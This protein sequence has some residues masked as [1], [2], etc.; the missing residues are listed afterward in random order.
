MCLGC[1]AD[2]RVCGLC[3]E[4]RVEEQWVVA[5]APAV[6]VTDAPDGDSDAVGDVEARLGRRDVVLA[7]RADDVELRDGALRGGRAQGRHGTRGGGGQ[8]SGKVALGADSVDRGAGGA[9]RLDLG[10]HAL[11]LGVR[12][13]VEVIVVDVEL[14]VGVCGAG[15]VEGG[16]DEGL[17]EDVVED[18]RAHAAV[19]VEDLVDDVPRVH[20]AL[21]A[22]HERRDVVGHHGGEGRPVG[23]GG[24]PAR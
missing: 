17:A 21:V 15:G 13:L 19:L 11:C 20:L 22:R 2:R 18:R 4:A 3:L 7:G 6:R 9:P 23:D 8:A 1:A 16:G 14:G 5:R 24:D 10:D 12:C